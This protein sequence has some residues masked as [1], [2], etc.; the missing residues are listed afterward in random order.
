M[1]S[2]NGAGQAQGVLA[3]LVESTEGLLANETDPDRV[4]GSQAAVAGPGT[5]TVLTVSPTAFAAVWLMRRRTERFRTNVG[6]RRRHAAYRTAAQLLR[7]TNGA[8]S[9]GQARAAIVGY[10]ADKCNAPA[11]GMTRS[12]A[13]RLMSE[14]RVPPDTVQSADEMLQGFEQAEYGGMGTSVDVGRARTLLDTLER[15]E[16]Q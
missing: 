4:L 11:G 12:E 16:L 10:I 2:S 15:C 1:P 5:W 9:P 7:P 8:L 14:H 6:L 13:L 3:P